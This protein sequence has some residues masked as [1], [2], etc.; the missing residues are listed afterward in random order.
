MNGTQLRSALADYLAVRRSLGF[1]LTRDGLLLEQ[2]V[3]FCER[4]DAERVTNELAMAWVTAPAGASPAWLGMRLTVVRGFASWL[5]AADPATEV[6]ERGWLPPRWRPTPYLYSDAE[7]A[8]LIEAARRAR[9]R[10]SAATYEALIGL[11]VVTGMRIGEAIRL[12]RTDVSLSDGLLTIRDTKFGKSR[13]V[14]LHPSTVTAVRAYL[15]RRAA[16]SPTPGEPA[17]FVHPAGNRIVYSSVGPMFGH[18]ARRA[19]LTA[20]SDHCR[21]TIHGLRHTYAVNTLVG[22]YR[23]GV[24]VQARLPLLSTWM[25]HTDP[26]STYWYLSGSLELLALANERLEACLGEQP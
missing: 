16:L 7:I 18:L 26:K 3:T 22:W 4:A 1:K 25:G 8:A 15:H 9:W 14:V 12:D 24:D 20:R 6:P 23:D 5:Q 2:F 10:L 13:H 21:P 11:L 17:L 19:G